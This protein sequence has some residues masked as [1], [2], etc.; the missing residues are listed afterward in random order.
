MPLSVKLMYDKSSSDAPYV[1]YNPELDIA[2]CGPTEEKARSNLHEVVEIV[3]EEA[4]KKNKLSEL[5]RES[6]LEKERRAWKPPRV[7][8]EPFFFPV[9]G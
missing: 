7:S 4:K 5:L 9:S 8:F 1:A 3:I 6:G 2:S